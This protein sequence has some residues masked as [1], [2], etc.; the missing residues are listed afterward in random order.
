MENQELRLLAT[1]FESPNGAIRVV[2]QGGAIWFVAADICEALGYTNA[3]KA[4]SDNLDD[5][6]RAKALIPRTPT[7]KLG[8]QTNIVSESGLY[9]L[10][11]RSSKPTRDSSGWRIN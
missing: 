2:N 4:L 11:F 6:E 3:S 10:I 9:A 5:D 1:V 7:E 8:V